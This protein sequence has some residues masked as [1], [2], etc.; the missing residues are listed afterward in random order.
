MGAPSSGRAGRQHIDSAANVVDVVVVND[1]R[2]RSGAGVLHSSLVESS[3]LARLTEAL[4]E[5]QMA[6]PAGSS[7]GEVATTTALV[8]LN[9]LVKNSQVD[10]DAVFVDPATL[11]PGIERAVDAAGFL[12]TSMSAGDAAQARGAAARFASSCADTAVNDFAT[13]RWPWAAWA[14][15]F[16]NA[17][18]RVSN[19]VDDQ[20]DREVLTR[21]LQ[22]FGAALASGE[23]SSRADA[24][25]RRSFED[26][27]EAL[28]LCRWLSGVDVASM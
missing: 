16:Q 2:E 10:S 19:R 17:S 14:G 23:L 12:T 20:V 21:T 13:G 24:A 28:I 5:L 9:A 8:E 27:L 15:H 11:L 25:V 1:V 22:L 18:V 7:P 3:D 26:L 4:H 6:L